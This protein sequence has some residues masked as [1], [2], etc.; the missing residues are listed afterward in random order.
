MSEVL[1]HDRRRFLAAAVMTAAAVPF[2]VTG[3]AVQRVTNTTTQLP[4]E[5]EMSSL[6]GAITDKGHVYAVTG[7]L[8]I[9]QWAL[10]GDWTAG[11]GGVVA[12][13]EAFAFT[14]G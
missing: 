7:Q 8:S 14:F 5:G 10:S 3:C 13:A 4:A 1:K 12:G 2:G 6:G 11:K 9:N